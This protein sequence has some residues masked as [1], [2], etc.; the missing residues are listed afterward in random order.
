MSRCVKI[1]NFLSKIVK[2]AKKMAPSAMRAD[3]TLYPTLQPDTLNASNLASL[4]NQKKK[5]RM[6]K[7][8]QKQCKHKDKVHTNTI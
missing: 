3:S 4:Q 5:T 1:R 8:T 2:I 6:K 7:E